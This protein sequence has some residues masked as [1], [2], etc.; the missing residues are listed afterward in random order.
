MQCSG[1]CRAQTQEIG[2]G[3]W[4]ELADKLQARDQ[5]QLDDMNG[6][7]G[8]GPTIENRL[9][10]ADGRAMD[11]LVAVIQILRYLDEQAQTPPNA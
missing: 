2:M 3:K 10:L 4:A 7:F 9:A 6:M 11:A 5:Q 1:I 8:G